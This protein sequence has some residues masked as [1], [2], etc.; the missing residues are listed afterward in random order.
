MTPQ[1]KAKELV[2]KMYYVENQ[3]GEYMMTKYM[4]KKCALIA[5]NELEEFSK[6]FMRHYAVKEYFDELRE[7]I[8]KL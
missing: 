7:E 2:L 8:E 5:V 3:I 1:E 6:S 4:S